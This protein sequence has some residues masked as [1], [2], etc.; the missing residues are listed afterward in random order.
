MGPVCGAPP[1]QHNGQLLSC[2]N[3]A[4][5]CEALLQGTVSKS[6][7][8]NLC[9]VRGHISLDSCPLMAFADKQG[10]LKL[11]EY[12]EHTV[13]DRAKTLYL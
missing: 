8:Y 1:V 3:I 5:I 10:L 13:Y 11:Y 4:A 12:S 7:M 6:C 9:F 2:W